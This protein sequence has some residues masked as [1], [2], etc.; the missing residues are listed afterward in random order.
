MKQASEESVE[1]GKAVDSIGSSYNTLEAQFKSALE[2][3]GRPGL[4]GE[5]Q[6]TEKQRLN[7]IVLRKK[8]QMR[9]SPI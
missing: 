6:E 1:F 8:T 5:G 9:R 4:T 3:L 2:A 7:R